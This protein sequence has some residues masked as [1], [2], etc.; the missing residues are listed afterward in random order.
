MQVRVKL[1]SDP[2]LEFWHFCNAI[3]G[4]LCPL[5]KHQTGIECIIGK[6]ITR[7]VS[8]TVARDQRERW[9]LHMGLQRVLLSDGDR[10]LDEMLRDAP[11]V[12]EYRE[13]ALR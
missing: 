9:P 8:L 11:K 7:E 3:A 2:L 1:P 12:T 6:R 5:A 10:T 4:A 13:R